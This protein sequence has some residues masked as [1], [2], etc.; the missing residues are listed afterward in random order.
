M[1]GCNGTHGLTNW[2]MCLGLKMWLPKAPH[3]NVTVIICHLWT[4]K[5][6]SHSFCFSVRFDCHFS[7]FLRK[8]CNTTSNKMSGPTVRFT[9]SLCF[10][11]GKLPTTRHWL[12]RHF[13]RSPQWSVWKWTSEFWRLWISGT[14]YFFKSSLE[15][16]TSWNIMKCKVV[17]EI[18]WR[19]SWRYVSTAVGSE[20]PPNICNYKRSESFKSFW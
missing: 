11:C 1:N 2:K 7:H 18:W 12:W 20:Q 6:K 16:M 5:K 8:N 14:L 17:N 9:F 15:V 4:L 10:F 13:L 19:I 3:E